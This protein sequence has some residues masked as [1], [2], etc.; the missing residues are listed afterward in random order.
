[1]LSMTHARAGSIG[2]GFLGTRGRRGVSFA[3]LAGFDRFAA[4][5]AA[6][7]FALQ[8]SGHFAMTETPAPSA[9]AATNNGSIRLPGETAPADLGR[10]RVFAGYVGLPAHDRSD[11]HLVRPGGTD[12]ILKNLR[13][14][15]EPFNFPLY[16]GV[17][18][19]SWRGAF[20]GMIDFLHD[21][22]IARTGKGA[23]GRKVTGE[24][25]IA[26]TI[27]LIGTLKGNPAPA[28]AKL[29]GIL[30]RLEF[31]HGHNLLLPTAMVRFA[32][33]SPRVR[34]YAGIGAGAALPHV[35]VW[36]AAEG[37]DA[38]TNEYQASGPAFQIVFGLEFSGPK[39]PIFLEYKYT[40]ARLA[41]S[42][43]GGKTP[44]WCNCDIVTDFAR[45]I[46][47]WWNGIAPK[48]GEF[49][50]NL[51]THQLVA[52]AGYRFADKGVLAAP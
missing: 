2:T 45:H 9:T 21:K 31:S 22:A 29:T 30:E 51:A 16:A 13:W 26:D 8:V 14:D 33:Y 12:L 18:Y 42:L 6:A 3:T 23:H 46:A 48:Y 40:Y 5:A 11:A 4:L 10:E 41:T 32:A 37:E 24:R 27:D 25:A 7:F 47:N 38:K 1:M 36:P 44:S 50:T 20:G 28:S 35:E 43:T 19:T 34:P 52:G 15:A 49:S 17:R 39:G